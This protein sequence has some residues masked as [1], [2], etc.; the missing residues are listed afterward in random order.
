VWIIAGFVFAVG[1]GGVAVAAEPA[2]SSESWDQAV[3]SACEPHVS[4]AASYDDFIKGAQL[5]NKARESLKQKDYE[6]GADEID[7]AIKLYPNNALAHLVKGELYIRRGKYDLAVGED[8]QAIKL[9]PS[10]FPAF[11]N[12]C[13]HRAI[14]GDDLQGALADCNEALRL[15]PKRAAFFDSRGFVY[16]KM[17][18]FDK[19]IA[20]YDAALQIDPFHATSLFGRGKAR[21]MKGDETPGSVDIMMAEHAKPDIAEE[22]ARYGIK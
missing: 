15:Y 19:A 21:L 13:W 20:D 2:K 7:A 17:G 11:N 5:Y 12:R 1:F 6:R 14:M 22:M 18:N 16:L 4:G 3:Q 10:C 8:S 9:L